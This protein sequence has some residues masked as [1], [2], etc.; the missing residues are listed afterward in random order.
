V[1]LASLKALA[2]HH[3]DLQQHLPADEAEEAVRRRSRR[4]HSVLLLA[5]S[6]WLGACSLLTSHLTPYLVHVAPCTLRLRGLVA[7]LLPRFSMACV[8]EEEAAAAA[9]RR[10]ELEAIRKEREQLEAEEAEKTAEE[11][12]EA[13]QQQ[14]AAP[15]PPVEPAEEKREAGDASGVLV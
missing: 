11:A 13:G 7:A 9:K 10:E 4:R 12:E 1:P 15:G 3:A 6:Y 5:L 8:T 2:K 14:S